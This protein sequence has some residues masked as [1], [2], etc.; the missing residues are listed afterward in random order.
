METKPANVQLFRMSGH[1]TEQSAYSV[2]ARWLKLS[3]SHEAR[4]QA[5]AAQD[6][7][8]AMGARRAFEENLTGADRD[9]WLKLPFL[10]CDGVPETGQAWVRSGLLRATVVS[11]ANTRPA[12]EML[13][14]WLRRGTVQP[15]YSLT[16]PSSFPPAEMLANV[17]KTKAQGC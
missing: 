12:L 9:R 13:V 4:I 1:W 6:D 7:S 5:I 2:V 14:T 8:M 15:A 11:P 17:A 16:K 3:T 10:G